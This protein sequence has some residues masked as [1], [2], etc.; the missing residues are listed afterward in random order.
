MTT[1][2]VP[3]EHQQRVLTF[4]ILAALVMRAVFIALG[5]ALLAAFV[6]VPRLRAAPDRHRRAAVPPPR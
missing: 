2:A 5:A 3:R 4:G 6:H 1:F